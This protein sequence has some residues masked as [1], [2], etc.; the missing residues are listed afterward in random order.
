MKKAFEITD[1]SM[2]KQIIDDTT[3]GT[4]ALCADDKPYSLPLNFVGHNEE[5]Y[6]H[7]SK[8]GKKIS[9]I[10]E[11]ANASF[12]VVEEYSI[13]PSYFSTDSGDASP[14]TH[15]FKSVIIDGK[16]E[17]VD[18]YD[19]KAQALEVL[20][21]KYQKEGNY[22]PLNNKEFYEKIINATCLYKL[23]PSDTSAKFK[24]GQNYNKER[25]QRVCEHL[26]QRGSKKDLQT[27]KLMKQFYKEVN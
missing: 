11:N 9:I 26:E 4:L 19:E 16:I 5:I 18:N 15:L 12:S 1:K 13:L 27:L 8:K 17:F 22:I 14:A 20:M 2:I 21:Q 10:K 3:Y 24:F 25:F 6:F 23:V 7:G